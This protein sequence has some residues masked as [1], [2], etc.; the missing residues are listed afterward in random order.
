MV[1]FAK[2]LQVIDVKESPTHAA[3]GYVVNLRGAG[4]NA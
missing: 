3:G 2:G 4:F 1:Q